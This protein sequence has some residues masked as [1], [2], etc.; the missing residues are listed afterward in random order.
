LLQA[1]DNTLFVLMQWVELHQLGPMVATLGT[2]K[3]DCGR[4]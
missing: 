4:K 1:W 2:P 3:N